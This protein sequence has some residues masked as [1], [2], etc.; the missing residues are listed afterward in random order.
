MRDRNG[1]DRGPERSHLHALLDEFQVPH[2]PE[3]VRHYFCRLGPHQL[4]WESHTE[5]F[6]YTL[7]RGQDGGAEFDCDLADV[8]PANWLGDAPGERF[9]SSVIEVKATSDPEFIKKHLSSH[10]VAESLSVSYVLERLSLPGHW[11]KR[12]SWCR[13]SV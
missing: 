2:P 11:W 5:F 12:R 13:I 3:N 9:S 6:S 1:R 8:L 7:F 10:F 4:K